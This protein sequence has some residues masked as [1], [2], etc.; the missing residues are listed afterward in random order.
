V[1]KP[2]RAK[3][4]VD[5]MTAEERETF[6]GARPPQPEITETPLWPILD[7]RALYG[8]AGELVKLI[9]PH[10]ESDAAALLVQT[11]T[12]FGNM[13]GRNSYYAVEADRHYP[14]IFMCAVGLSGH[15]RKGTS[16]GQS[17]RNLSA[18]DEGW[19]Q[20]CIASGLSSGEGLVHRVRNE[21]RK[22]EPVSKK[23]K[24]ASVEYQEVIADHGVEDKRLL[25]VETE[26]SQALRVMD[27]EGNTLSAILRNA[28]DRGDLDILTKNP[29]R[30][31]GAHISIIGHITSQ[32]LT[33]RLSSTE[34]ANGFANRFLWVCVQRSKLLPYGG[35]ISSVDFSSVQYW[36]SRA[37]DFARAD[38]AIAMD[39]EAREAWPDLYKELT[40][41][42]PGLLGAVTSRAEAQTCR[43]ALIYALLDSSRVIK[44]EHLDA[45]HQLWK[46]C[47]A[48]ARFIFSDR[49]G[50]PI[51]D[52]I[53][54]ALRNRAALTR[55]E[56]NA[57]FAGHTKTGD[58][59]VALRSLLVGG[60]AH[61]VKQGTDGRDVETWVRGAEKAEKTPPG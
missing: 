40:E 26:F 27:R 17:L 37:V 9:E 38:Q 2:Q 21:T 14:N 19:S 52:K 41:G 15:G 24:G 54:A 3:S 30:A 47:E 12:G 23:K 1:S 7:R 11:L 10:T 60:F 59:D 35:Q 18:V 53:L 6:A 39:M 56:I 34:T 57:L 43:L 33:K 48:S 58:I 45:A 42:R 51:A 8:V 44:W 36:L 29:L 55:T 28:W 32:E 20:S 13:V 25:V 5:A 22:K 61:P 4:I 46:Y 49:L 50:D 16:W 31:T